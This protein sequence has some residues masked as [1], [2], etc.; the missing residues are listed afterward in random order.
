MPE[1]EKRHDQYRLEQ[2]GIRDVNTVYGNLSPE[3]LY[4]ESVR[5]H[6]GLIA[7]RGPLVVNTGHYTGRSPKDKFVVKEPSSE[8]KIWWGEINQPFSQEKFDGLYKRLALYLAGKDIF[9]QDCFVCADPDYKLPIRIMTEIAWHS[10]FAQTMFIRANQSELDH[11]VPKFT[12][13]SVPRFEAT[14]ELD[15]THSGTF[16]IV[17]FAKRLILIGGT[18]YAGEIKKSIFT[19]LNYLLPLDQVLSMHCSANVGPQGDT[20]LF[21]G[22]SGTGK[23]TLSTDPER[24]LIGDDEHGWSDQGVFN[25][26]GG[27]YAKVIHLSKEAEPEIYKASR[28]FGTVLENVVIDP[29]TRYLDFND[30]SLTENTRSAYPITYI[31]NV[32]VPG[33]AGH[34]KNLVMLTADAFGVM[35]PIAKLT[36]EQAMYHFLSGYTAKVA[37]TERG[38]GSEPQATFSTCFGA[39]FLVLHPT[40]YS[41]ML[42]EKIAQHRTDCWLVNTGWSGG[43][44]GEGQRMKIAYTRAMIQAA[45]SG[46]LMEA[47]FEPDPVFGVYVPKS[48]PHVPSELLKP[49]NTWKNGQAY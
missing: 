21:F 39:P 12:V 42:G 6:E 40:V 19:I 20:A 29:H 31:S 37:G 14:P 9:I 18:L 22:L 13:I 49:R 45:L 33:V 25:F 47:S 46:K 36:P 23:T 41:R 5:R 4:E 34:P 17:N 7:Y 10:L 38:M 27:C 24:R 11:H 30:A 15:G 1:H 35:P 26:E 43:P 44:Y 32:L 2:Y 28:T 3:A 48:C 16:I 8:E